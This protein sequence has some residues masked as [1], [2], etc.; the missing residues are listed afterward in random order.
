VTWFRNTHEQRLR[1]G[2]R[3]ALQLLLAL[4]LGVLPILLVAEP[5]TALH[6]RGLFLPSLEHDPYDRVINMIVG[7]LLACAIVGSVILAARFLDR[8]P[9]AHYGVVLDRAWWKSLAVGFGVSAA[10][11]LLLF[12]GEYLAGLIVIT[13]IGLPL[14]FSLVKV[15]CVGMYEEFISRGYLL[16]NLADGIN[17]PAA[18][19]LSS[20]VFALLHL[21]NENSSA[22]STLGIFVNALYFAAAALLTGRLSA[23]IGAHIGWNL[24]EGAILGFPVSGDKEGASLIGIRQ[25]GDARITGGDFGPEAGV[26]GIAASLC[27]IAL[28]LI[29]ARLSSAESRPRSASPAVRPEAAP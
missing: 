26:A 11:M 27:G 15:L 12:G 17:M 6:R 24:F 23:A 13:H 28:F 8:R 2:W 4:A 10:V 3:I 1:A 20:L 16:R 22:M 18:I 29:V 7:P 5:L 21:T 25:L 14:L 19:A 9:L